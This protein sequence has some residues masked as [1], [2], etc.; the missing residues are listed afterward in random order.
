MVTRKHIMVGGGIL[1]A[2]IVAFYV[3]WQSD[4]SKIKRRFEFIAGKMEK[5]PGENKLISGAKANRMKEAFSETLGIEAPAY[6]FSREISSDE[7][8]PLVLR[9]RAR[10]S[11]ISLAFYD[12]VI[13]FHEEGT[14]LVTVTARME[15]ILTTGEAVAD[16]HELKCRL[17]EIE[18]AWL[19]RKIEVV[20]VLKK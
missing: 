12:F 2:G 19:L 18:D 16:L 15:G 5:M 6:S 8:S 14:A 17:Q 3:F 1:L 7:L 11:E 9:V 10:Y 4:E 13:D 20:E